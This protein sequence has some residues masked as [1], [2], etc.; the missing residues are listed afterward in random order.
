MLH[1]RAL[2][3]RLDRRGMKTTT[4]FKQFQTKKVTRL[5]PAKCLFTLPHHLVT[6]SVCVPSPFFRIFLFN[7]LICFSVENWDWG[8]AAYNFL[9]LSDMHRVF[10]AESPKI[11]PLGHPVRH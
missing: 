1:S 3:I 11:I 8:E 7:L 2:Q 5:K 9:P 10:R 4:N 6:S